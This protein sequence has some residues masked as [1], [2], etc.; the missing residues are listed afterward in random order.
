MGVGGGQHSQTGSTA[1]SLRT[2]GS[3]RGSVFSRGVAR[4]RV[5]SACCVESGVEEGAGPGDQEEW[6]SDGCHNGA[7]DQ[8]C[9]SF[10]GHSQEYRAKNKGGLIGRGPVLL[11]LMFLLVE[12]DR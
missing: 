3:Q 7:Q 10:C 5:G 2:G 12:G 1:R 9:T 6:P 11:G 4:R 8:L